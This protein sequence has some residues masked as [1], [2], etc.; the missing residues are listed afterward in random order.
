MRTSRWS[1]PRAG[2]GAVW[3]FALL[4]TVAVAGPAASTPLY[5]ARAGRTCDNCHLSPN[6]WQNPPLSER[7]CTLSCAACHVDPAGGGIRNA[8]GRFYGRSTLPAIATSPRPTRDWDREVAPFLARRDRAT[9][10]SD[11]LPLG[12]ATHDEATTWPGATRDRWAL[13]R[14]IG[15][16]S[17][18]AL[19][20]G[21]YGE[22]AADPLVRVGWDLRFAALL[23][24]SALFFPMQ[25]D[26]SAIA[27]PVEHVSFVANVGARGRTRG[28]QEVLDAPR[29]PYLRE[30]YALLHEA[31]FLG[32]VKAG[33]FVPSFGLRL[34][35]HT[36]ATRRTFG[37]DGSLP[38]TRVTGIEAGANPN[39]PFVSVAWFR[40]TSRHRA[41][42][43]FDLFELDEGWGVAVN[44]GFR[45]LGWAVGASSLV[46]RRPVEGGGDETSFAVY[47]TANPWSR[48]P[49]VP[50]TYQAELD[51]GK[52]TRD[53]GRS[54][55]RAAFYHQLDW[56]LGNGV[57]VVAAQDW[58]DPD[59]EVKDDDS[60]RVTAGLQVTPI[61]GVTL[62]GRWRVLFPVGDSPGTDAF[63]QLHLW[64]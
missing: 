41:P 53:S 13:G 22:L 34:D 24:R 38:E 3:P 6:E 5:A 42:P 7:K 62:D 27:H 30:G 29:S 21:R 10:Y 50:L 51:V 52:W 12:P 17:R 49:A 35:D 11:S 8:A 36:A 16:P 63:V 40:G 14:A 1:A 26:V 61:P 15:S 25:F 9:T 23:S 47:G 54:T 45:E 48:W 32:Y 28:L 33:R 55:T 60:Y 43:A 39:Y 2:R 31:P 20:P 64:N 18:R 37:L 58:A 56:S 4:L 57:A 44:A 59:R 46:R 19:F